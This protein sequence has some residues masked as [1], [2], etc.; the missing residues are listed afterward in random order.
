MAA[1][2]EKHPDKDLAKKYLRYRVF[3]IVWKMPLHGKV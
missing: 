1:N 2:L 3:S